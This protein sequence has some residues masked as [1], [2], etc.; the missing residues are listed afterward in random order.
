M[1]SEAG[2]F[3]NLLRGRGRIALGVRVLAALAVVATAVTLSQTQHTRAAAADTPYSFLNEEFNEATFP[4]ANWTTP[5]GT[6]SA[7]CSVVSPE[8]GCAAV[9][10]DTGGAAGLDQLQFNPSVGIP[11]NVQNL[12][13]SFYSD[14]SPDSTTAGDSAGAYQASV[15]GDTDDFN[16]LASI[17]GPQGTDAT[18]TPVLHTIPLSNTNLPISFRW[19]SFGDS[20]TTTPETWAITNVTITGTV[21]ATSY[22]LTANPISNTVY[23]HVVAGTPVT[24]ALSGSS[25]PTGDPLEFS[26]DTPPTLGALGPITQVDNDDATV[27]YTPPALS[28]PD[29]DGTSGFL[30]SDTF[31]F[32]VHDTE[33]NVS[34]PAEVD[35]DVLPGGAGNEVPAVDA[36]PTESYTTLS[37][38]GNLVQAADLTGAV[39]VGPSDFPDEIQLELQAS[40]GTIDL[41]N[42]ALAGV[43][44]INGTSSDDST[45]YMDGSVRNLNTALGQFLYFPPSGTTPT[46]TIHMVPT[47][48]GPTG[49]GPFTAGSEVTTTINGIV[50]NPPPSLA[51]PTA[52]LSIPTD[53][54]PLT[55][56]SG[57]TTGFTLTDAGAAATTQDEVTISVSGGSL[58][59]PASDTSGPTQLVTVQS[60]GNGGTLEITGTV[61]DI[62]EALHDLTFDPSG[63][64]SETVTLT[65]S[66]VDPDTQLAS[67]QE[68][69]SIDVIEAPYPF[70]A[71]SFS[72]LEGTAATFWLCAAGPAGDALSFTIT[73]GPSDGTLVADPSANPG[74]SGCSPTNNVEAFVY[75]PTSGYTGPD[76][77]VYT[78]TDPTTG[79]ESMDNAVA[80]TVGPHVKPTAYDVSA[81]TT[82]D[83]AVTV[84]LC[85]EN[86]ESSSTLAFDI[87][88]PPADGTL[89]DAGPS[90]VNS[91]SQGNVA[92][93]YT[94]TPNAGTFTTS[95]TDTFTYDVTN[96]TFSD[97]ATATIN[98][99]TLTP[100]VAGYSA[101]VDE[102]SSI[103]LNLCATDPD[104]SAG[105]TLSIVQPPGHGTLDQMVAPNNGPSCP[106]GYFN[107]G[108][109]RYVPNQLYSGSDEIG[110]TA[111]AGGYTSAE[112]F[113][114][115]TV[116]KVEIPPTAN[117]QTVTDIV[118]QPVAVALTG[119]SL[120][121]S[122]LTFEVTSDPQD[123]T[124]SG[125]A[126]NLI[127]TPSSTNPPATDS[128]TFVASDGVADSAPATVTIDLVVPK[129]S[130]SVCYAGTAINAFDS[131][132]NCAGSLSSVSSP[133]FGAIEL[134]HTSGTPN[135]Q[136]QL[137]ETVTNE[138]TASDTV[139]LTAPAG[140]APWSFAYDVQGSDD[141]APLTGPGLQV[142]LG[143]VG[144]GTDSVDIQIIVFAPSAI[145][146]PAVVSTHVSAVSGNN[147]SVSTEVPIEVQDGTSTPTLT[148]AQADGSGGVSFPTSLSVSPPLFDGGPAGTVD[149][150]NG[151][152]GTGI[153]TF[154][155]H[156]E[157]EAGSTPG[158]TPSFFLGTTN[159]T[160]AVLAGT[161]VI[162][163]YAAPIG[164][165]PM[166]AELAPGSGSGYFSMEISTT[167]TI[168]G[169]GTQDFAVVQLSGSVGP[170]LW[171]TLP[172]IGTGV[173]E[174]TPVTQVLSQ[175]T[176]LS[177]SASRTVYL[178]NDAD[179][180]DTFTVQAAETLAAGDTSVVSVGATPPGFYGDLGSA[181]DV[182]RS[183]TGAGY[184]VTIP[185]GDVVGLDLTDTAG[186]TTASAPPRWCSPR[187]P[188]W[189]RPRSTPSR[190]SSPPTPT[191]PMRSSRGPTAPRSVPA[192]TSRPIPARSAA[193]S[194]PSTTSTSRTPPRST[195]P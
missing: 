188:S 64:P 57:A 88:Q 19:T 140:T 81:F 76:G 150:E 118:P 83:K 171:T 149:I 55:F 58:A 49:G 68:S 129:L 147:P 7:S 78:V 32:R 139:T 116:Q 103:G 101:T 97:P 120:Q 21:P 132:Y 155:I 41:T 14:F 53:A 40:T 90:S 173:Y 166:S 51:L 15:P 146:A 43:T 17:S 56:P 6:W 192:S 71:T 125:T 39:T 187:P 96:G 186:A 105:A 191:A 177:G 148:L 50:T 142:T 138:S 106:T 47:D 141:T 124:L 195:S 37:Q 98:V 67:Q 165:P 119:S 31:T 163:C 35:L 133:E 72:T 159:V 93:D 34:T 109:E 85:A 113:I 137:Q 65:A 20:S 194:R 80:I 77:F 185:A 158:V 193:A 89:T 128:F 44:F 184:D 157:V 108:Y 164:C 189:T 135:E 46:A 29:P 54:G 87:V 182:T 144:S 12:T 100:A 24:I 190:S 95:G 178:Q 10:T 153:N 86:P 117:A 25:N 176:E 74:V 94:Y 167:S 45:I 38:N 91:C 179:V 156:A 13:L 1:A 3:S 36:P 5:E 69:I 99:A 127:Y 169:Q 79:L 30:C 152:N 60:L 122:S 181:T 33:G 111:S 131:E 70:G 160:A 48:M 126:P 121:G 170:D 114:D 26:V 168:D 28:C 61:T 4:P 2:R 59:L 63:L 162:T 123:G 134:A 73:S 8:T 66:A 84:E 107:F 143:P 102:D 115:L 136:L 130:S 9:A 27:V 154:A 180:P 18:G 22:T 23:P 151:L 112:S 110:I 82:E 16:L 42:G 183:I 145:P 11:S 75:T 92:E 62:N 161:E 172:D 104:V 174:A 175:P 52:A